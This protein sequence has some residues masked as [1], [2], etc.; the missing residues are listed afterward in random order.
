MPKATS[1]TLGDL[2]L[3][4]LYLGKI[5]GHV[6]RCNGAARL[7]SVRN[8]VPEELD[9]VP[10]PCFSSPVSSLDFLVPG[11]VPGLIFGS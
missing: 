7:N 11:L 6:V 8:L 5:F 9:L 2:R 3:I 1:D 4:G 10:D